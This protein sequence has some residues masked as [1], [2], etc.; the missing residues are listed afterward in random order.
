M[1]VTDESAYTEYLDLYTAQSDSALKAAVEASACIALFFR[2]TDDGLELL[3]AYGTDG[4]PE[5]LALS[6]EQLRRREEDLTLNDIPYRASYFV[7]PSED[8]NDDSVTLVHLIPRSSPVRQGLFQSALI[9]FAMLLIFIT[10]IVYGASVRDY[11]RENILNE[12]QAELYQPRKVRN[13][14]INSGLVGALVI[15]VIAMVLQAIGHLSNEIGFGREALEVFSTQLERYER[16]QEKQ[17]SQKEAEWFVHCGERL[18]ALLSE[19]PQL[20]AAQ[21]LQE[22]CDILKIDYIMLFDASGKK[23]RPA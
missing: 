21:K 7:F 23:A 8:G 4:S 17:F 3:R 1:E 13:R 14:L 15:F 16:R 11:V 12:E 22:T 2:E 5:G 10:V 9:C 20:A 19:C 18:S 6:E